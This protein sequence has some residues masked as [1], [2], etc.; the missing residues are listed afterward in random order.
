MCLLT[1]LPPDVMPDVEALRNGMIFNDD[2][3]GYAIVAGDKI[4][5]GRGLVGEKVLEEFTVARW[6]HPDGPA[7]YHSRLATDGAESLSNVHPFAIGGDPRTVMAHN[8]IMPLRP[9]KGDPRSDTRLVA[10]SYIPRAYRNLRGR[11][12]RLRFQR[13]MGTYNKVVILTV[14]HRFRDN[15]YIL[16]EDQGIWSGGAWYS[17]DGYLSYTLSHRTAQWWN[18]YDDEAYESTV[19]GKADEVEGPCGLCHAWIDHSLTECPYCGWCTDCRS[20]P[21]DCQCYAPMSLK[22]AIRAD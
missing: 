13:W 1:Y 8:G 17:N 9:G 11:R 20:N 15:A 10:E 18:V 19:L 22:S 6:Q 12:A 2:G 21:E 4:I 7:L 3:H 16:N 5:V 14:D